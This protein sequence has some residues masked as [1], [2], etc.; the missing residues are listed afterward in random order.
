M[1]IRRQMSLIGLLLSSASV[2]RAQ[3]PAPLKL[4]KTIE[5]R[6]VEGRID[7]MSVDVQGQRLFVAALG[8]NT[9]EVIDLKAGKRT[10][11][12]SGVGEPQGVLYVAKN[13]QLY[14]AS[15]KDGTVKIFDGSS[16]QLLKTIQYEDDA[17]NL[18]YDSARE[19]VYVGYGSGGLGELNLEGQ[20]VKEIPL[21][22]H[23]ESFQL[24]KDSSRIYVNLPKAR[25][26]GLVDR[27]THSL[28][29]LWSMGLSLSN[30]AMALDE[31]DHRLFVVTRFPAR[32]HV[33]DTGS[34]KSVL[35]L[36]V[37]GD[38]DDVFY[39]SAQK[40]IYAIGGEGAVSVFEQRDADHYR[41]MV[42]TETVK[43]ARTGF[44][45]PDLE[46]L[47][48]AVRRQGPTPA[49]IRIFDVRGGRE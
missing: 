32:L 45:S 5:L 17:D 34:G 3:A 10:H 19:R 2:G 6:E 30:Y 47:Y 27:D 48:V 20:K 8:N 25:E 21:G 36:P 26:I 29:R 12:I 37:V 15:S 46:R 38:C 23:P 43:G 24:E 22:S 16:F 14:V 39:D 4:E 41:E 42:R 9:V 49:M 11:T 40:R 28:T 33:I 13:G 35:M 44:F 18:R 1:K 31:A 7:H